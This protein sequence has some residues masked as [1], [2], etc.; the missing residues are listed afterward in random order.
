[1]LYYRHRRGYYALAEQPTITRFIRPAIGLAVV[2]VVLYFTG[3]W[4]LRTLGIGNHTRQTAIL[5]SIEKRGAVQVSLEGK[6]YAAAQNDIKLYASDRVKTG[7][8]ANAALRFFDG[9]VARLDEQTEVTVLQSNL[10]AENSLLALELTSGVLWLSTPSV[11]VFSGS[12]VRTV[13]SDAMTFTIPAQTD[14]TFGTRSTAVYAAAGLGVKIAIPHVVIPIIVGEGQQFS[15]PANFNP[16]EDLYQYRSPIVTVASLPSFVSESRV[17]YQ[18]ARRGVGASSPSGQGSDTTAAI[19][20]MSP[21]NNMVLRTATVTVTG[22][23]GADVST[24]RVNGY[25]AKINED[26]TFSL[27]VTPP[28]E[29]SVTITVEALDSAGGLLGTVSRQLTRDRKPPESPTITAP[30]KDGQ[31]YR[32]QRTE[33]E[34]RGTASKDAI[35]IVVNDYRLQLFQ[36]GSGTWS[37]LA[38]LRLENFRE[39]E[40]IFTVYAIDASGNRSPSVALTVLLGGDGEGVVDMGSSSQSSTAREVTEEELPAN[41]PLKP[42]TVEVTGPVPGTTYTATGAFLLEGSAPPETVSVWVNGYKLR[43]YTPGKLF[44]NYIADPAFATLKRGTNLYKVNARDSEGK[45]LDTV[46]YT[47]TY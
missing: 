41:A 1:M 23:V 12:I 31:T 43:L 26:R 37:Y 20:L 6:D 8:N 44:W 21:E 25:Q 35:G 42:G 5:L 3:A 11:D 19:T 36:P 27:E 2:L 40:N 16:D 38:S 9:S 7:A 47:V 28:D 29:D 34:I 15:L 30:A 18:P 14:G 33:F 4:L 24:L 22:S 39:G 10:R 17:L 46:T 13:K 32:T 45:I